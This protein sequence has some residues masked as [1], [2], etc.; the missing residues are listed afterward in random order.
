MSESSFVYI[1]VS[2]VFYDRWM[3]RYSARSQEA[4]WGECIFEVPGAAELHSYV[5]GCEVHRLI[6][7]LASVHQLHW[8]HTQYMLPYLGMEG[9]MGD[10]WELPHLQRF[11]HTCHLCQMTTCMTLMY[12]HPWS[13]TLNR[14]SGLRVLGAPGHSFFLCVLFH[15]GHEL[16]WS[17]VMAE[18]ALCRGWRAADLKRQPRLLCCSGVEFTSTILC[19][20]DDS[21]YFSVIMR[22]VH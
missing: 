12:S 15:K 4:V 3:D 5:G 18:R 14:H 21:L 11:H 17:T 2:Y 22:L 9:V 20:T 1:Y 6:L 7:S 8:L 13:D 16:V 19:V 10:L